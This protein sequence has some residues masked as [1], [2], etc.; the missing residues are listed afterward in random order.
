MTIADKQH[1]APDIKVKAK[2]QVK[3]HQTLYTTY[4]HFQNCSCYMCLWVTL[5]HPVLS[6]WAIHAQVDPMCMVTLGWRDQFQITGLHED[7]PTTPQWSVQNN[8]RHPHTT[9]KTQCPPWL[10][11][12]YMHAPKPKEKIPIT[13]KVSN[14][15]QILNNLELWILRRNLYSIVTLV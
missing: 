14:I 2:F 5:M 1:I 15:K 3:A 9:H 8:N 13:R 11:G 10:D 12:Y 7:P 4:W 6:L